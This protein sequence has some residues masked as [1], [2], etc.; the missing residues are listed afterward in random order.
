VA[1]EP[2]ADDHRR[3]R[4]PD[5]ALGDVN[6]LR[7]G[8][9][10]SFLA[11]LAAC[12]GSPST[13]ATASAVAGLPTDLIGTW[14]TTVTKDDLRAKGLTDTHVLNENSGTFTWTLAADGTW[15]SVQESLDNSPVFNPI[16][17]GTWTGVPGTMILTTTFPPEIAD[18]GITMTWRIEDGKLVVRV[19]DPPDP[20]QPLGLEMHPWVRLGR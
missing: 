9:L 8:I 12:G 4:G 20:L 15:S 10:A 16:A 18:R 13:S 7:A 2:A 3:V 6:R 19:P 17:R 1:L 14:T 5:V 11:A